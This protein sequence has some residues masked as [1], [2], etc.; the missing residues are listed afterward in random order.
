MAHREGK[1]AQE[2][3]EVMDNRA[4]RDR[5][6][7][8]ELMAL[9][10]IKEGKEGQALMLKEVRAQLVCKVLQAL[11]AEAQEKE[12]QALKAPL[13]FKG[14]QVLLGVKVQ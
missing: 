12:N 11:A 14:P 6:E 2:L 10:E 3:T 8:M 7:Q 1:D 4:V 5:V 9:R 13:E